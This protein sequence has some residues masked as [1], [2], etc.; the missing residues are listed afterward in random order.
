MAKTFL[1]D[2][3]NTLILFDEVKFFK[4]FIKKVAPILSDIIAPQ[5]MWHI[6]LKATRSVLKNNGQLTNKEVFFRTFAKD[7]KNQQEEVW[8]RFMQFYENEFDQLQSL[9]HINKGVS[10]IFKE[11]QQKKHNIVIAS[12]PFWPRIAMEKR[13]AWAGLHKNQVN[14][15]THLENMHFC[16]PR[17]EYYQEICKK[18]NEEPENFIMIGNDPVNDMVVGELGM[19]TFLT[20]DSYKFQ[21]RLQ[22]IS[23]KFR[24]SF[25]KK[26]IRPDFIGPLTHFCDILPN[27]A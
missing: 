6:T 1:F 24:F 27:I 12:N 5:A 21:N 26:K 10:D 9:I 4:A 16:K 18:F 17:L 20:T 11:L 13:M 8:N 2:L 23:K 14:L 25:Q 7:F 19:K 22:A 15:I 3:D